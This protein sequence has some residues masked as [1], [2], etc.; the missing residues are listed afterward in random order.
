[1][2]NTKDD[3]GFSHHFLLPV[4]ALVAVGAIGLVT[5]RLSSAAVPNDGVST[6]TKTYKCTGKIFSRY[7]N[8]S[9]KYASCIKAIQKKVGASVD[10]VYGSGTTAKVKAWQSKHS[11]GDDGVV[12]PKTWAAM[13]IRPTYKVTTTKVQKFSYEKCTYKYADKAYVAS[14]GVPPT[15]KCTKKTTTGSAIAA[16]AVE[17]N[18]KIVAKREA[19]VRIYNTWMIE[20]R[21][22]GDQAGGK[23]PQQS[24]DNGIFT[25]TRL[26]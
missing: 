22:G 2:N 20:R 13:G 8:N 19:D 26:N 14:Y 18:K 3:R 7:S 4:L 9:S 25:V 12:G 17:R 23:V 11:L 21:S 24:Y 15:I 5:L 16:D 10:G 1:M 6:T